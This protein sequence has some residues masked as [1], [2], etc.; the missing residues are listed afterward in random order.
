VVPDV[1]APAAATA[2][3][4]FLVVD[5]MSGAVF[6]E[7]AASI[8]EEGWLPVTSGDRAVPEAVVAPLPSVTE[9]CRASLIAGALV[10]GAADDERAAFAEHSALVSASGS[11]PPVWFPKRDLGDGGEALSAAVRVELRSPERRVVGA[12]VNAVDDH[13]LKAE[14]VRSRWTLPNVPLLRALLH[15]AREGRRLVVLTADHGHV[16]ESGTSALAGGEADRWRPA[17][18]PYAR[19]RLGSGPALRFEL[20][21]AIARVLGTEAGEPFLSKRAAEKLAEIRT[22]FTWLEPGKTAL[23]TAPDGR[24]RWWTFGG[25]HANTALAQALRDNN[26]HLARVD[27]FAIAIEQP[28]GVNDLARFRE[29]PA[30]SFHTPADDRALEGLKFKECLPERIA[31]GELERRMTDALAVQRLLAV[32]VVSIQLRLGD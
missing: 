17:D 15:A 29:L 28:V 27:N 6:H 24:Q 1:L 32:P 11:K 9:Y 20:C 8:L 16:L 7:L 4:L 13:L 12:V 31:R 23:V 5:G 14:Q 25:L 2:P 22:E 21:Q 30:S 18:A 26:H 3:V 10:R 19:E